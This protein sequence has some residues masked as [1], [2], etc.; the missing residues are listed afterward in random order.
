MIQTSKSSAV[1]SQRFSISAYALLRCEK[2]L[3]QFAIACPQVSLTRPSVVT[4]GAHAQSGIANNVGARPSCVLPLSAPLVR[5]VLTIERVR[6][7]VVQDG[8]LRDS[9]RF[10]RIDRF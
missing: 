9:L 2:S 4:V 3:Y 6:L 7:V 10:L 8:A 5:G 1:R